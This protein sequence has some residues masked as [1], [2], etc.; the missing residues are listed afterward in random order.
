MTDFL[1]ALGEDTNI[2]CL[3]QT[4]GMGGLICRAANTSSK[5]TT[6]ETTREIC[7][8]CPAGKI[9]RDVGCEDF[10]SKISIIKNIGGNIRGGTEIF[11]SKRKK[12]TTLENCK[13]CTLISAATTREIVNTVNDLFQAEKHYSGYKD[14]EKAKKCLR[15]GDY[16]GSIGSSIS[17]LESVMRTSLEN[18]EEKLPTS[19]DVTSL[20]KALR[21]PLRL[22][23]KDPFGCSEKLVGTLAG[24][25]SHLGGL[26]NHL[27]DS[28]GKGL[29]SPDVSFCIA[30]LAINSSATVATL[31]IRRS[32]ELL[33]EKP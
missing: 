24:T 26:R 22:D 28:H 4:I 3:F 8:A 23:E 14:L 20:W 18:L 30:E 17:C 7:L 21:I 29:K 6:N 9:Y 16:E 12:V 19:L 15:D 5:H 1:E 11:C 27:S 2:D 10:T 31:I 13:I 25:V 32:K 33:E